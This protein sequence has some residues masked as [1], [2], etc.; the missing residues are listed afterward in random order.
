MFG[1]R[2]FHGMSSPQK[3]TVRTL[4][5][6]TTMH[7]LDIYRSACIAVKMGQVAMTSGA[8]LGHHDAWKT[9]VK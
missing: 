1:G 3:R 7:T 4:Q 6:C 5:L 9:T 2:A 8:Q